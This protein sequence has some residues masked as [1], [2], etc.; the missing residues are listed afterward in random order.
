MEGQNAAVEGLLIKTRI[1]NL[2]TAIHS[3]KQYLLSRLDIEDWHG[4]R[5]AAADIEIYEGQLKVL[6]EFIKTT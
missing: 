3:S 6:N 4:V 2:K 5:D 1:G